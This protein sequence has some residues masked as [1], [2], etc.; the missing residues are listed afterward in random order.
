M[1]TK[2]KPM[3]CSACG[4]EIVPDQDSWLTLRVTE[5]DGKA[6]ANNNAKNVCGTCGNYMTVLWSLIHKHVESITQNNPPEDPF[7]EIFNAEWH[8]LNDHALQGKQEMDLA[9]EAVHDEVWRAGR[10]I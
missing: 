7:Y 10:D 8:L 3:R 5:H 9:F 2:K 6:W 4:K 1:P